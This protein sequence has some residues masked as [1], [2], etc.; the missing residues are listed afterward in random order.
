[1][2]DDLAPPNLPP[3]PVPLG[4]HD[5]HD[6]HLDERIRLFLPGLWVARLCL[7]YEVLPVVGLGLPVV[8]DR[9]AREG[10]FIF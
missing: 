1:M 5:Q 9:Q 4:D 2:A 10:D 6:R 8:P 7:G 3:V